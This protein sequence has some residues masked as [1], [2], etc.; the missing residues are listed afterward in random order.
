MVP[1]NNRL[2]VFLG[3]S[4][5]GITSYPK[6]VGI[7]R[8]TNVKVSGLPSDANPYGTLIIMGIGY[9]MH[10]YVAIITMHG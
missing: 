1:I 7:Y 4:A 5:D 3:L 8:V 9:Y 6:T 10:L 2:I